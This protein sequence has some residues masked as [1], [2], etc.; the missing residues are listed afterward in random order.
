MSTARLVLCAGG[1]YASFLTWALVQERLTSTPYYADP[2]HI[3]AGDA[4]PRFFRHVIFLNT[5]QSTCSA[6]AALCYIAYKSRSQHASWASRLGLSVSIQK[7]FTRSHILTRRSA[8]RLVPL[9]QSPSKAPATPP[10]NRFSSNAS[11]VHSW[12]ASDRHLA[13]LH[14]DISTT[15]RRF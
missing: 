10:P 5:V 12:P 8:P 14:C 9:P 7:Q 15:P 1:I 6:L 13:T 4:K 3:R 2:A 11:N